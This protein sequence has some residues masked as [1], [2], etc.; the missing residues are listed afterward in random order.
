MPEAKNTCTSPGQPFPFSCLHRF[1]PQK[2][3]LLNRGSSRRGCAAPRPHVGTGLVQG[4]PIRDEHPPPP[5]WHRTPSECGGLTRE[6]MK[7]SLV[8]MSGVRRH[9]RNLREV[10]D[11][12]SCRTPGERQ[13]GLSVCTE[14]R[15]APN[16]ICVGL[17]QRPQ[18][19]QVRALS[20]MSLWPQALERDYDF[21]L[22]GLLK[23]LLSRDQLGHQ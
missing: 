20:T 4:G 12:R 22:K 1:T 6:V 3:S 7:S 21:G 13:T 2:P 10:L 17:Y 11:W 16:G 15:T 19:V 14:P 9:A 23:H 18:C 8:S 5:C